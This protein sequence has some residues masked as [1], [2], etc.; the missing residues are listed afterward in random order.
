MISFACLNSKRLEQNRVLGKRVIGY[1]FGLGYAQ[2]N[3]VRLWFGFGLDHFRLIFISGRMII[4]STNF[5]CQQR[6][7][8]KVFRSWS[9]RFR[10]FNVLGLFV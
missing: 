6:T 7:L 4:G 9:V 2:V 5:Y 1:G 3:N 10:S 8:A